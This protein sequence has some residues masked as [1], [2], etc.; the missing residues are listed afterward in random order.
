MYTPLPAPQPVTFAAPAYEPP[1]LV[2]Y[3]PPPP[4]APG[5]AAAP[6]PL[7]PAPHGLSADF[8]A[9]LEAKQKEGFSHGDY[10]AIMAALAVRHALQVIMRGIA[11]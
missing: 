1:P 8:A 9:V 6:L 4:P 11:L 5:V 10:A 7:S 3:A 2:A